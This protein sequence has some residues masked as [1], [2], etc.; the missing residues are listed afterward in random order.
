MEKVFFSKKNKNGE[1][2]LRIL[3]DALSTTAEPSKSWQGTSRQSEKKICTYAPQENAFFF[4]ILI[5][6]KKNSLVC[7]KFDIMNPNET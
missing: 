1:V 5:L 2:R 4:S 3:G 7:G 6:A